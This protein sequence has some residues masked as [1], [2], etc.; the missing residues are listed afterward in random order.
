MGA[1]RQ[2]REQRW[3]FFQRDPHCYWCGVRTVWHEVP[4]KA[5]PN[6]ATTDHVR[7]RYA[8][9]RA[10]DGRPRRPG[11][12]VLA[13]LRCNNLRAQV[14]TEFLARVD[15]AALHR[16]CGSPPAPP[17]LHRAQNKL[18]VVALRYAELGGTIDD[19]PIGRQLRNAARALRREWERSGAARRE[20]VAVTPPGPTPAEEPR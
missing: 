4:G 5:P 6:A 9:A 18:A 16:R 15:A 7:S 2:E 12:R 17:T 3:R 20:V 14:E 13:C 11:I 19:T 8:A 10:D 1:T